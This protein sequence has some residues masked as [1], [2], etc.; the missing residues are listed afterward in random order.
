MKQQ[1]DYHLPLP[2]PP[3]IKN[4][5]DNPAASCKDLY[6]KYSHAPSGYYWIRRSGSP[7]RVY[8]NMNTTCGTGGWM[9]VANIDM[10][11]TS[12]SCPSG[13]SLISSPKRL[14]DI[15]STGCVSNTFSVQE[16][17]YSHVCGRVLGYQQ[18]GSIAFHYHR[19]GIEAAYV[20][21]VSLTH[22][23]GPRNHIW[24]FAG[25]TDE[26][27]MDDNFKC[28]CITRSSASHVPS[29]VGNDYVLL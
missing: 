14:C 28:P 2:G 15:T 22:G 9:R 10:R 19:N 12:Q 8:C 13:L 26:T 1:L 23:Q 21:G 5:R 24:T 4:S 17:Q 16:V 6:R 11:N 7:V 20:F 18:T 27:N 29:F 25:A 3:A